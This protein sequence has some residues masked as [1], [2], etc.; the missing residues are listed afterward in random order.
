[1]HPFFGAFAMVASSLLVVLHSQ[2]LA[3]FPLPGETP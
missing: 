3:H 2:R 1:L